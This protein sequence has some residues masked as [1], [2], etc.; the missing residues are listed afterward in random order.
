VNRSTRAAGS[1]HARMIALRAQNQSTATAIPSTKKI[2]PTQS[3]RGSCTEFMTMPARNR[4]A[5]GRKQRSK[6]RSPGVRAAFLVVI[7]LRS[8]FKIGLLGRS[9]ERAGVRLADGTCGQ[10]PFL[11]EV[12]GVADRVILELTKDCVA[13][14]LVKRQRLETECIQMRVLA[15]PRPGFLFGCLQESA[16]ESR[17]SLRFCHPQEPDEEPS[18]VGRAH[19]GSD[20]FSVTPGKDCQFPPLRGS[21]LGFVEINE[22]LK[23]EVPFFCRGILRDLDRDG[24]HRFR[25][26]SRKVRG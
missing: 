16:A 6:A 7:G 13:M 3:E 10:I 15:S 26:Y 24:A 12:P 20:D 2:Q 23:D 4:I 19:G 22:M 5:T 21:R 11:Q 8:G 17:T 9:M 25:L 1:R 14:L 18:K